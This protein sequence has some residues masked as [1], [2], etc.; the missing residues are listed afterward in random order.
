MVILATARQ[1][2]QI[3]RG[4]TAPTFRA[5]CL[6]DTTPVNLTTATSARLLMKS[7]N[8][9][10]IVAAPVTIEDQNTNPGWVHR[11]WVAG[12]TDTADA[13]RGEVEVTWSDGTVQTFPANGYVTI[14]VLND[15][16]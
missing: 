8:G 16:G 10:L 6:D 14:L 4:D 2:F 13:Y 5:Q 12:D 1:V 11:A 9:D 15:L 3:K 7:Q